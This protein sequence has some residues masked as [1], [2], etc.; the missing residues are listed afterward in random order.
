[1]VLNADGKGLLTAKLRGSKPWKPLAWEVLERA[2]IARPE[3][4]VCDH[5]NGDYLDNRLANLRFVSR[6]FNRFNSKANSNNRT[7]LP[8]GV[9][10]ER[11]WNMTRPFKS[12]IRFEGKSIVCGYFATP[13]EAHAAYKAKA[14]ELYGDLPYS[15]KG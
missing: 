13:E 1:M 2:G 15:L 6:G 11:R 7:G 5:I 10:V 3:Q 9:T 4:N 8:R 12:S 14:L